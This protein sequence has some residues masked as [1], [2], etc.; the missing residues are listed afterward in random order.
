M[1][2]EDEEVISSIKKE[3][4][5]KASEI[6]I[7]LDTYDDIFSDFDPRPYSERALSDD[8]LVEAKK[9]CRDKP[10]GQIELIFLIPKK[11]R[12]VENETLVKRRLK[13]HF[14]KH[15]MMLIHEVR[16]TKRKGVTMA[17]LGLLMILVA[18]Y[19]YTWENPNFLIHF[20]IAT[21]EPGGWFTGW[22]GL[23]ELYY[24]LKKEEPELKFYE[25]MSQADIIF[26]SH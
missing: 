13:D 11:L 21:L 17:F 14:R 5:L 2:E 25:R 4:L 26:I 7:I 8:L 9:A 24:T 16:K 20:L 19:L 3:K 1:E 12:N 18:T 6:S 22:T 23:D 10:S 15:Y